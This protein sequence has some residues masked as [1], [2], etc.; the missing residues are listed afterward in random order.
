M[1]QVLNITDMYMGILSSLT[2]RDKISLAT[3]L[4]NSINEK[5]SLKT[6][7]SDLDIRTCFSGD[8]APSES[9]VEYAEK[10]RDARHF[11]RTVSA[12]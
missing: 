12:W 5:M 2:D 10:L 11:D 7:S 6:K 4:L 1:Q 3:K 8:W 9:A